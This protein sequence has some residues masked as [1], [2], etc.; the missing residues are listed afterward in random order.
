MVVKGALE[1]ENSEAE[2]K[3]LCIKN[4]DFIQQA[5]E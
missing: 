3:K 1:G 2:W 4:F 5:I